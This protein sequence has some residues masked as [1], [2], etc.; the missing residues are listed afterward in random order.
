LVLATT[1]VPSGSSV[2]SS[3]MTAIKF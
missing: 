3:S 2:V 1:A